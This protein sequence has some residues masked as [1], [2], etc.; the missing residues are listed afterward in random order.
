MDN[1]FTKAVT[2]VGN[3]SQIIIASSILVELYFKFRDRKKSQ[4]SNPDDDG[5]FSPSPTQTPLAA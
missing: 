1:R 4:K 5:D 3:A 2:L